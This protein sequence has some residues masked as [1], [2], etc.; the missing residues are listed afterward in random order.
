MKSKKIISL[1]TVM[2][3]VISIIG[4]LSAHAIEKNEKV[5]LIVEVKGEA[6]LETDTAVLM[7]AAEYNETDEAAQYM[8]R[9]MSV[10]ENV[11][12]DIKSKVNK[13]ADVGFTYTNVLNGFSVTVNKSDIDKIKALPNVKDVHISRKSKYIK[14]VEDSD[15]SETNNSDETQENTDEFKISDGLNMSED[16]DL[17][18]TTNAPCSSKAEIRSAEETPVSTDTST[19]ET[20][21]GV[22]IDTCCEMINLQYMHEHGYKGQ[23]QAIAVIDSELDVNHEMFTSPIENPKY[24][25]ADIAELIKNN[26][27]NVKAYPNQVYRSEKIP[28]A[29]N[30]SKNNADV[31]PMSR[32]SVHGTH[33]CGIVA[34][35]NGYLSNSVDGQQAKGARFSSV[36]PEAQI[37][38]MGVNEVDE[39]DEEY[40][41]DDAILAA[42]DDATKMDIAAINMSFGADYAFYNDELF[43]RVINTAVDASIMVSAAAGNASMSYDSYYTPTKMIDVSTAGSPASISSATAVGSVQNKMYWY[44]DYKT[45]D[46][47]EV[48]KT[49]IHKT[50]NTTGTDFS[51]FSSYGTDVSLELKPEITTPGGNIWSAVPDLYSL[52]PGKPSEKEYEDSYRQLSGTSMAAPHMTGAAAL[53]RQYIEENYPDKYENSAKFIENLTMTSA[54]ILCHYSDRPPFSPRHQGAGLLDLE[55]ATKTPVILLGDNGK[56][57]ISLKDKLTDTFEIEFTAKNFTDTDVTYDTVTLYVT[58]DSINGDTIDGGSKKIYAYVPGTLDYESPDIPQSVTIPAN[59]ETKI[60]FTVHL[61]NN[62]AWDWDSKGKLARHMEYFPN[63][64]FIDGFV[65]LSDSGDEKPAISIP[66]TGFYGDWT[67]APAFDKPHYQHGRLTQSYWEHQDYMLHVP[68]G[69]TALMSYNEEGYSCNGACNGA[70][71]PECGYLGHNHLHDSWYTKDEIANIDEIWSEDYAG[72]SPNG[73]DDCDFLCVA[74]TPER[75]MAGCNVRIENADGEIIKTG[76]EPDRNYEKFLV[77][78]TDFDMTGVPDGDYTVYVTG[79]LAYEG[80]KDEEISMKF[81]IDTVPPEITKKEIREETD[82]E[83]NTKIYLDVSMS[84]DRYVMGAR[85]EGLRNDGKDCKRNGFTKAGKTGETSIDITNANISTL[86]LI[87]LDYAHNRTEIS[88]LD[89]PSPSPS[90]TP[91][92]TLS[93]TPSVSPTSSPTASPSTSP[94]PTPSIASTGIT[95][96]MPNKP[97]I[98]SNSTAIMFDISNNT[99]AEVTADIIAAVYDENGVLKAVFVNRGETLSKGIS[100]QVFSFNGNLSGKTVKVMIFD[101]L[102]NMK[103]LG[104]GESFDI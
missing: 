80:A 13:K 94:I 96:A 47:G 46:D 74:V 70:L 73:D 102:E 36:A 63:G 87:A 101:S 78:C 103:P 49:Y 21:S 27:L 100:S 104:H 92:I 41:S 30:Y 9:I 32:S 4:V 14:P 89:E 71:E 61:P 39:E 66:Y 28:F 60:K 18:N 44:W 79:H 67:K 26:K 20:E 40:L 86:K 68:M 24:S 33:V 19:P 25:K 85:V 17:P 29:Y 64:F 52:T 34:G 2:T 51:S 99:N 59:G 8:S 6:A 35:K 58:S 10:Q 72:L 75:T 42:V 62:P 23:G 82:E 3:V 31:Y 45:N 11:Q 15:M 12:S 55:A 91:D 43:V 88:V 48:T 50:T 84:D 22:S 97:F 5:T 95:V 69:Y 53:I 90:A 56:T 81:Y 98:G 93:P 37:I 54:K 77:N 38:F 65:E 16:T 1:L 83:G 7:G 57:K 76:E